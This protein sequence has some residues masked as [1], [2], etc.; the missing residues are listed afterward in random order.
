MLRS[1]GYQIHRIGRCFAKLDETEITLTL[2]FVSEYLIDDEVSWRLF[3]SKKHVMK[4]HKM[5]W[6]GENV[7][8]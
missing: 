4:K 6:H 1:L 5:R 2:K 3:E 8:S 7:D